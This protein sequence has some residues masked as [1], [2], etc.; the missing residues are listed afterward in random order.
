M[1]KIVIHIWFITCGT[2]KLIEHKNYL[3]ATLFWC[4]D[5]VSWWL[6]NMLFFSCGKFINDLCAKALCLIL[7]FWASTLY[8]SLFL[9][10][11]RILNH[12]LAVQRML[13]ML[14]LW[15][16][17]WAFE[18]REKLMSFMNVCRCKDAYSIYTTGRRS[19][20]CLS[21]Y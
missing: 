4:L 3:Q 1:L 6:K 14:V 5:Y 7:K 19:F 2:E 18:E 8:S 21:D 9:E 16:L 13:W 20:W 15:L 12:L 10:I 17:P 11:T